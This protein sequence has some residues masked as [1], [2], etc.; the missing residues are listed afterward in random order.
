MNETSKEK[1]NLILER[2]KKDKKTAVI[3]MLAFLGILLIYASEF[4]QDDEYL[5]ENNN[6]QIMYSDNDLKAEL[7]A[8]ISK[9]DG[10]GKTA[11]MITYDGTAENIYALNMTEQADGNNIKKDEEYLIID[12]GSSEDGLLLKK[13]YPRVTGVAVVCDGGSDPVVKN[14]ITQLLKALYNISSNSISI[15][16]MNS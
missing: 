2:L 6:S 9:I 16:E 15:S 13:V 10:V 1:L 3:I 8:L 5:P 12:S 4:V 7:E 14:E 11:V